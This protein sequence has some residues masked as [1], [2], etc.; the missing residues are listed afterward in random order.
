M[1]TIAAIHTYKIYARP[2]AI[3]FLIILIKELFFAK[4]LQMNNQE[5]SSVIKQI[6]YMCE[7]EAEF[8]ASMIELSRALIDQKNY[9]SDPE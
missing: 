5:L 2:N 8:T 6:A 1:T 4:Y 3:I 9:I 7:T